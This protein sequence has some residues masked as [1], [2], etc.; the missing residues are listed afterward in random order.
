[1]RF[2]ANQLRLLQEDLAPALPALAPPPEMV[3]LMPAAPAAHAEAHGKIGLPCSLLPAAYC[4][5]SAGAALGAPVHAL[6][7]PLLL[8]WHAASAPQRVA[9]QALG[10]ACALLCTVASA[11]DRALPAAGLAVSVFFALACPGGGLLKIVAVAMSS[12]VLAAAALSYVDVGHTQRAVRCTLLAALCAQ[13]VVSTARLRAAEL[14]FAV[15][16]G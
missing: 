12:L 15:R 5:A 8:A 13:A 11:D 16:S 14:S 3:Q 7:F 4:L 9:V 10:L 6:P 1:M 2:T